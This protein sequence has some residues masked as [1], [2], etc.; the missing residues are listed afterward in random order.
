MK[1]K[2]VISGRR[3]SADGRSTAMS[4]RLQ[5][6]KKPQKDETQEKKNRTVVLDPL[7]T[8][9]YDHDTNSMGVPLEKVMDRFRAKDLKRK[10]NRK[11]LATT[12]SAPTDD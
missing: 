6:V 5:R 12:S 2:S 11:I 10:A 1:T 3:S 8:V 4:R 7:T 9:E